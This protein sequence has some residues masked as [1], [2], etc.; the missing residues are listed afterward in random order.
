[1]HGGFGRDS[2][3]NNMAAV[4]PDF[5]KGFVDTAPISNAD[6]VPILA[7]L[8]HIDLKSK[9]KLQG[10]VV[11][12]AVAG[13]PNPAATAHKHLASPAANGNQTILE[14]EEFEGK[15]YPYAACF[16]SARSSIEIHC[17]GL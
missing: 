4:G 6:I 17:E 14:Y 15:R 11:T 7:Q 3:Y 9:G 10:R 16:V 1:M 2:T 12:E 13:N 5:K 8:L